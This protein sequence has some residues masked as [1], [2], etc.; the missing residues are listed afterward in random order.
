MLAV[1][2]NRSAVFGLVLAF[3]ALAAALRP[4]GAMAQSGG[5][6]SGR[7]SDGRTAAP[8]RG[9]LVEAL[10]TRSVAVTD[11]NG[12]FTLAEVPEGTRAVRFTWYGYRDQDRTVTVRAAAPATLDVSLDPEPLQLGEI[13][14]TAAS[15]RPERVLESPASV[16]V[17]PRERVRDLVATGQTP[18]L[19]ADFP[20]VQVMQSGV[21]SFSVNP[22][23]FN[24][25][26][27]RQM[28]V[29]VDGMDTGHPTVGSQEW[30][31]V[32]VVEDGATVELV[33]GPGSALYGANAF[34][35]VLAITTPSARQIQGTRV[36]VSGG[37][38]STA[39]VDARHAG[40][41][42]DL[43]W[44]YQLNGA[45]LR[46]GSW[47]RSRT[48]IGD[49][50]AEYAD[51]VDGPLG[52]AAPP[53]GYEL[54]PL[55]GQ[56]KSAPFGVPGPA[57]GDPD[58][59]TTVRGSA[60][61]ERYTLGGGVFTAEGGFTRLENQVNGSIVSRAQVRESTRPW[62]RLAYGGDE[63]DVMAYYTARSGDQVDLAT[64][65]TF[66]DYAAR[67]HV[68]AQARRPLFG[69]RGTLVLGG[70]FR[71]ETVDT[72]GSILA[73]RH[74]GRSDQYYALFGQV[75]IDVARG[76]RLTAA[77]RADDASLFDPEFSP[78][79]ALQW[80]PV[81]N[82]VLR[83][84]WGRAYLMPTPA[85]R[86]IEFPI[87]PPADFYPLEAALR[88]SAL[89][90]ALAGVPDSTLF[91]NSSAVS[92][93][94]IGNGDLA[95]GEVTSVEAGYRGQFDRLFVTVEGHRSKFDNFEAGLL[96]WVHPDFAPW[97]A[98]AGVAPGAEGAVEAAVRGA[99]PGI[100]RLADGTTAVVFSD[101][102][103]GRATQSGIDLGLS[104]QLGDAVSVSGNYSYL[105]VDF[106][107][108]S[109]IGG[110]S[111][112]ANAP[113]QSANLSASYTTSSGTRARVGLAL[114]KGFD[115]RSGVWAG[116]VPG[117]QYVDLSLGRQLTR[118]LRVGLSATNLFDQKRFHYFGGS[119]IGRRLLVSATWEP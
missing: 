59:L 86:F 95:P 52:G 45:Y 99:V 116:P 43:R 27:P 103:S 9:I 106:E 117:R 57:S 72:K 66:E 119:L 69:E 23:G 24:S 107:E 29:L 16:D 110:D 48:D 33:R 83:V 73:A 90:P 94:A 21:N 80:S 36:T 89:G 40:V 35:G 14:I 4:D 62:G 34:A 15:R 18:L 63:L 2:L 108:G 19:I 97:A 12:Q 98:P 77:A 38:L 93:L 53:P 22:R 47:D 41:T 31:A 44:G 87:G 1:S 3:A 114:V 100:T 105:S 118:Q 30:P 58:P 5:V 71:N 102:T 6:V 26:S 28:L 70:S 51:A 50:D 74:D 60:R 25:P 8:L 17:V 56:S 76:L 67:V 101:A 42:G 49:L 109:L 61:L 75:G 79:L 104:L 85:Q 37:D 32:A 81:E 46:S 78:K 54:A 91:T 88:A 115:F 55:L 113:S 65:S 82:H 92:I 64:G 84:T 13:I 112:A 111:I 39:G 10:G 20:G 7:V 96:P 68:E 11:A